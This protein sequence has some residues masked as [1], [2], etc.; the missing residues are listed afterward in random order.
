MKR[1]FLKIVLFIAAFGLCSGGFT[2][3]DA[4]TTVTSNFDDGT[5]QGW[6]K[7]TP[8]FNPQFGGSLQ[9]SSIGNPGSSMVATDSVG[10]GGGL[11]AQAPVAFTGDL[12]SFSGISWD[13]YLPS[14][15]IGRTSISLLGANNTVYSGTTADQNNVTVNSW[16]SRFISFDE[17]SGNWSLSTGSDSFE[18]LI[19]NVNGLYIQMDVT[20]SDFD[21][22]PEA[23]VDNISL[24]PVPI[25]STFILFGSGVI[26]FMSYNKRR[27]KQVE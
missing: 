27:R 26:G 6:T 11:F 21:P 10:G 8:F 18:E 1:K 20:T 15:S 24:A 12:S 14:N 4:S 5:L 19:G 13:E 23:I 16:V 9:V 25:P 17:A 7:G 22:L 2:T 3:I